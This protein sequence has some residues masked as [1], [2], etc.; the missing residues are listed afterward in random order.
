MI[1]PAS[2]RRTSSISEAQVG[3]VGQS[4]DSI[5]TCPETCSF[6]SYALTQE[7]EPELR[8]KSDPETHSSSLLS[9][10]KR[11]MSLA[12]PSPWRW[13]PQVSPL[14]PSLLM[15]RHPP[16]THNPDSPQYQEWGARFLITFYILGVA[17]LQ[18]PRPMALMCSPLS[19]TCQH[20]RSRPPSPDPLQL[21]GPQLTLR[22]PG[23]LRNP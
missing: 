21:S 7:Q 18:T 16:C 1:N 12:L 5:Q 9:T 19:T 2:E 11:G 15:S 23:S 20:F 6:L 8:S 13:L 10:R 14:T 17:G 3:N 22:N 4:W